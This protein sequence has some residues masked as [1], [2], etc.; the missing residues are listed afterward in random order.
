MTLRYANINIDQNNKH[1][2]YIIVHASIQIHLRSLPRPTLKQ[3]HICML[4]IS[5]IMAISGRDTMGNLCFVAALMFVMFMQSILFPTTYAGTYILLI[6]N[7]LSQQNTLTNNLQMM[8]DV[9]F[10]DNHVFRETV[11]CNNAECGMETTT[12]TLPFARRLLLFLTSVA[13]KCISLYQ[14]PPNSVVMLKNN[15][16]PH[17]IFLVS[18]IS[19][20]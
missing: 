20:K 19:N 15:M 7:I 1:I 5:S 17:E 13:V 16:F 18:A 10:Y 14:V 9:I 2:Y 12:S 4:F 3:K 8:C 11:T 6:C